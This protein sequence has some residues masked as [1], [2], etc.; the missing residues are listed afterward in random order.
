MLATGDRNGG[1]YV[2]EPE[3]GGIVFT[4]GGHTENITGVDWR[5][6]SQMVATS[7]EDGR[8]IL[9]LAED[10]FPARTITAQADPRDRNKTP[11]VLAASFA[12]GGELV[13]CGRDNSAR[14]WN[15]NGQQLA[16]FEGFTD[17]P[18][19]A[20]FSHD[21]GRVFVGDFT[22]TVRVWDVKD[23]KPAGTLTTNPE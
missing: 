6:D 8:V 9:W 23:R 18:T 14:V 2:W 16:K 11:G 13:T 17:L 12:R 10:G 7:S 5:A 20:V 15:A 19:K 1:A 21:G 4:L 22:G 3:T